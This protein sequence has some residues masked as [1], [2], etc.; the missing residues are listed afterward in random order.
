MK[1]KVYFDILIL[2]LLL[3]ACGQTPTGQTVNSGEKEPTWQEQYDLGVRYLSEGNYEEAI[4]AFTAAIEI[5]PKQA[6]AYV[7]RGDAYVLSGEAEENLTA[8]RADYEKAIELDET[9]VDAY[10]G[11]A[12]IYITQDDYEKAIEILRNGLEKTNNDEKIAMKI[13]ELEDLRPNKYSHSIT[14]NLISE[15]EFAIAGVPFYELSLDEAVPLLPKSVIPSEIKEMA[16][17]SGLISREY[18]V[19][20]RINDFCSGAVIKCI[21]E[22]SSDTLTSL[23]FHDYYEETITEVQTG[24]RDIKTGDS[25]SDVLVKIGITPEGAIELE[26]TGLGIEIYNRQ[27]RTFESTGSYGKIPTR[28]LNIVT[29]TCFCMMSFIDDRLVG[30]QIVVTY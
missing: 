23:S 18:S 16:D 30:I 13:S 20:A 29:D 4:I 17:S 27:I 26:K 19:Y 14:D 6:P 11:L 12:N 3:C 8:A 15:E 28:G 9:L 21:Q 10:L 2:I 22:V 1:R 5:D 25:M 24:I 7:G